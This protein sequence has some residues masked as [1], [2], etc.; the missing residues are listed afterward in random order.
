MP[1]TQIPVWLVYGFAFSQ[2][3][4]ALAFLIIAFA[5][6]PLAKQL[7]EL[8]KSS[9]QVA[10]AAA[11]VER[12][13]NETVTTFTRKIDAIDPLDMTKLADELSKKE[14]AEKAADI[15]ATSPGEV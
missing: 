5:F 15:A 9:Q 7:V 13:S 11:V 6:L 2:F 14:R 12:S 1:I 4:L 8:V 10:E 3:A